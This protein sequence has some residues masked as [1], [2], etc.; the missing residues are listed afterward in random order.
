MDFFFAF[1]SILFYCFMY[2]YPKLCYEYCNYY[3]NTENLM[4]L[5]SLLLTWQQQQ[6]Q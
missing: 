4:H 1:Y 6:Q 5:N 2:I 3:A